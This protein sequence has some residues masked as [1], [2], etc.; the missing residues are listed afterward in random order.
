M[1][2]G[3]L[4]EGEGEDHGAEGGCQ[5]QRAAADNGRRVSGC[6]PAVREL[7]KVLHPA[8]VDRRGAGE[9]EGGAQADLLLSRAAHSQERCPRQGS[10]SQGDARGAGLPL[11]P[12]EPRTALRG[13][14]HELCAGEEEGFQAPCVARRQQQHV[15]LQVHHLARA[16][17][18]L[19]RRRLA[20]AARPLGEPLRR[21][22]GDALP[23]GVQLHPPPGSLDPAL[24]RHPHGRVLEAAP[25]RLDLHAGPPHG[26][27]GPQRR[28]R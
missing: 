13:L 23:Q 5:L 21:C 18:G 3:A 2:R 20:R 16:V 27:C 6:Q 12:A 7:R 1:D 24:L 17:P 19:R 4:Q 15:Q 9:A 28:A 25:R 14:H 10:H 8:H 22:V 11:L 26:V